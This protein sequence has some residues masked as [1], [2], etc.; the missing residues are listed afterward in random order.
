MTVQQLIE[1]LREYNPEAE[2]FIDCRHV[3]IDI[4]DS[5]GL[6]DTPHINMST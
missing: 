1:M 4:D 5:S 3:E 2:V 6:L